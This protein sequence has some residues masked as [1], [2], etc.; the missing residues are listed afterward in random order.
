[1]TISLAAIGVEP[2]SPRPRRSR[3]ADTT[4]AVQTLVAAT[5]ASR[6]TLADLII[7]VAPQAWPEGVPAH[8]TLA[9]AAEKPQPGIVTLS[10]DEGTALLTAVARERLDA[11]RSP[12]PL[13]EWALR[14]KDRDLLQA[15]MKHPA[16]RRKGARDRDALAVGRTSEEAFESARKRLDQEPADVPAS[17]WILLPHVHVVTWVTE[18]RWN[19]RGLPRSERIRLRGTAWVLI[20]SDKGAEVHFDG[21]RTVRRS[22]HSDPLTVRT[23]RERATYLR[24]VR[25]EERADAADRRRRDKG[26]AADRRRRIAALRR[27]I[28][29]EGTRFEAKVMGGEWR[30]IAKREV[31]CSLSAVR[32]AEGLN[33]VPMD[34]AVGQVHGDGLAVG[35]WFAAVSA[36]D[37]RVLHV[38]RVA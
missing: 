29:A 23:L 25:A 22:L 8:V 9:C 28:L 33:P 12:R 10:D 21:G 5:R 18:T 19:S 26:R 35:Q 34:L 6:Q 20:T 31:A 4:R 11:V 1:M 14:V 15:A 13:A 37:G 38:R 27:A 24:G 16:W 36:R 2:G 3:A 17:R 30:T 7:A 32:F